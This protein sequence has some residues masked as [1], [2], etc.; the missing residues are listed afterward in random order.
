MPKNVNQKKKLFVLERILKQKTDAEHGLT[1]PQIIEELGKNGI[2]AERKSIYD[3]I[4]AL[5]DLGITV[6]SVMDGYRCYYSLATRQFEMA[7][8][9]MLVD[10]IQSSNFL[11]ERK[12]KELIR[13][14]ENCTSE[15]E[16]KKLQRQVYVNG[17]IKTMN[18]SIYYNVD[19]IHEAI[20]SDSKIAFKY[21]NWD[22]NKEAKYRNDG[23]DYVISPWALLWESDNYYLIGYDE[24]S[25]LMKHYRVDKM[26]RIR[27]LPEE[28]CGAKEFSKIDLAS[29][30]RKNFGMYSGDEQ[31][32][33]LEFDNSLAN[34]VV[35]RFG[36]EYTFTPTSDDRFKMSVS[37]SV[38]EQFFGW[39]VGLGPKV[40]I[41]E[42]ESV[43]SDFVKHLNSINEL[44]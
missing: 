14:L 37:L 21:F 11:T 23:K 1:M 22:V 13:K 30:D 25:A 39:L 24:Q 33:T 26:K 34:V 43:K 42:P 10:A 17:R 4:E 7:E 18:E 27:I 32:V 35:D 29:Y 12:S 38:S 28:R 2:R 3:D 6:D 41:L 31:L 19:N 15:Y 36:K 5:G 8:L 9:K 40:K 16:A 20:S 44:Y